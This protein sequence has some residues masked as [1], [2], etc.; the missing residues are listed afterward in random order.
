MAKA[1]S[2][3]GNLEGFVKEVAMEPG[4]TFTTTTIIKG[5]DDPIKIDIA[6]KGRPSPEQNLWNAINSNNLEFERYQGYIDQI[7][8]C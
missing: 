2:T 6:S 3:P 4:D 5:T 8:N 7:L 1:K